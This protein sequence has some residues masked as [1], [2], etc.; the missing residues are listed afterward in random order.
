[1]EIIEACSAGQI[2]D[3]ILGHEEVVNLYNIISFFTADQTMDSQKRYAILTWALSKQVSDLQACPSE[4]K[5]KLCRII[6]RIK[7]VTHGLK[8][9]PQDNFMANYK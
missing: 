2:S 8:L 3:E 6:S 1:M 9:S 4:N 5:E 7:T